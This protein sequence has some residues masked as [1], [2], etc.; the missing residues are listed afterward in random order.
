MNGS[1]AIIGPQEA[2]GGFSLLGLDPV[3]ATSPTHAL[4]E[5]LRLKKETNADG[6]ARYAIIFI[7][8]DLTS[9]ITPDDEKRL[10]K[11][12]LPAIIPLPSHRGVT[13]FSEKRLRHLVERAVGSDILQ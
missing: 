4:E 10:A 7:T 5:L 9:S 2:I 6:S 3:P 1:L 12:P 13:G 11:D 8:E